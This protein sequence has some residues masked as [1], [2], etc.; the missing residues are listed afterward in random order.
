M[1]RIFLV[2]PLLVI[3]L[4]SLRAQDVNNQ[5]NEA[6][7]SYTSGNLQD[8]RFA[9]QQA[10]NEIDMAIGAE[11]MKALP[12]SMGGLPMNESEDNIATA[13][14]AGLFVSRSYYGS[15]VSQNA[16]INIITDSPLLSGVNA[17]LALPAFMADKDQK[18]VR[19]GGYRGILQKNEDSEGAV[20]WDLQVP[21][22]S[23]LLT[24]NCN[25]FNNESTVM[26]MINSINVEEIGKL[27]R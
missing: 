26:E 16:S 24:F 3:S 22:G 1:N 10:L 15:E 27:I 8:A 7:S 2:I 21:M 23:T 14:Y 4:G 17:L 25:G 13:G 11:I 19:V 20:S 5:L 12:V 18:R 6:R 9:L